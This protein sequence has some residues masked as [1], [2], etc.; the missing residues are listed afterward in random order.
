MN[1]ADSAHRTLPLWLLPLAAGLLP[2][3][4]TAIAFQLAVAQGQFAACNPFLDG[5]VS[6]SRAARHD[7]PNILFRALL[8]PAAT[9]Q[10][11]TWLLTPR[12]LAG[13]GAP[14]D[15]LQ[16]FLPWLGVVAALALILYGSFLGTDGSGY[17]L[18][19]RY[20][21]NLYFGFTC[22]AMLIVAGA[23]QAAERV[24][25]QR[26]LASRGLYALVACLPLLGIVNSLRTLYL[27]DEARQYAVGNVTEWWGG[28]IFTLYFVVV[29]LLWRRD[30]FSATM[31]FRAD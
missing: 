26:R 7:L 16:R 8:L 30:R 6:I 10:G 9:L 13:I 5:C 24:R 11:L 18:M 12:W 29:A 4:G 15:R 19:R 17:R 14:T 25:G 27:D 28:T 3:L 2:L 31:G 20:G 1:P 22:I 23:L 21:I